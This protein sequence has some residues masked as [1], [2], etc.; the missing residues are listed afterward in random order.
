MIFTSFLRYHRTV[1]PK[2][3]EPNVSNDQDLVQSVPKSHSKAPG[4]K[5]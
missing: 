5:K 1:N 2:L 3:E 4:G